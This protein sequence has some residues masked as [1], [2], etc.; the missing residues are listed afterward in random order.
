MASRSR[1][2]RVAE[3][4]AMSDV[5][6]SAMLSEM[7]TTL[8]SNHTAPASPSFLFML[9]D[10]IGWAD[11]GYNNGTARTPRIDAWARAKGSVLMQ[12][13][14]SGGTVCSPTRATVLTG[15]N[16][17]RDCVDYVRAQFSAQFWRT[18]SAQFG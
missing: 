13:F 16:H 5:A 10:D 14:H 9:A 15:R 8:A 17:F 3:L 11:F 7:P 6:L 1:R 2:L 12:D 4:A 18:P